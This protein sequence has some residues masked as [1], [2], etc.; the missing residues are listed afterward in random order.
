[1]AVSTDVDQSGNT[2][3]KDNVLLGGFGLL[4][5]A[6]VSGTGHYRELRHLASTT[7]PIRSEKSRELAKLDFRLDTQEAV[8]NPWAQFDAIREAT[9]IFW[10]EYQ[11][12]W[13]LTRHEDVRE[14][15]LDRR[16]SAERISILFEKLPKVV[17]EK[18]QPILHYFPLMIVT[19]DAPFHT[20]VRKLMLKGFT[21]Q[22]IETFRDLT[23]EAIDELLDD[24]EQRREVD[25]VQDF[26]FVLPAFVI[27]KLLGI[28][29][30]LLEDFKRWSLA[31]AM[32]A[33]DTNPSLKLMDDGLAAVLEMNEVHRKLIA[34]R[35]AEPQAD[36]LTALVHAVDEGDNLSEDELLSACMLIMAAGHETT[37]NM[38]GNGLYE[39]ITHPD[40]EEYFRNHPEQAKQMVEE[41]VRFNGVIGSMTRV[42]SEDF[43]WHGKHIK[44]GDLVHQ[45]IHAA[46]RDPRVY[47]NPDEL[48]LT[49][50]NDYPL[51]FGPGIHFCLGNQLARMELE[52]A[53]NSIYRRF[54]KIEILDEKMDWNSS[55]ALRGLRSFNVRFHPKLK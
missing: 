37:T 44:K 50:K 16:M 4:A 38:L 30:E 45:L 25:F 49:R 20:R 47:E 43:E 40:Q 39:L 6:M 54:S 8:A 53:F 5:S 22:I 11:N 17:K 41:L 29:R 52:L 48:D 33:G 18:Y 14:S 15:L 10:S 32:L 3:L 13:M 28:P 35:R 27:M 26:C 1:M 7:L 55:I 42:A 9:P 23:Q 19:S 2:S 46:N 31:L 36:F 24:V 12:A 21:N 34:E 51:S